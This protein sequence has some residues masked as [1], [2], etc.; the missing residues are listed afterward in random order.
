MDI[1]QGALVLL[2]GCIV[3]F[4]N[5]L[6]AGGSFLTLA[7][8]MAIGLP[9]NIANGTNRVGLLLQNTF[10]SAKFYR[11][12]ILKTKFALIVSLPA[13]LGALSGSYIAVHT[14]N[15]LLKKIIAILMVL[16]S[17]ITVYNPDK[18][19]KAKQYSSKKWL[20]LIIAFFLIGVYGGFIQAGVGFFII[21]ASLWGGFSM[22][23]ANA[24]K[25]FIITLYTLTVLPIFILSHQVNFTIGILLGLGSML[26]ARLAIALSIKKGDRFIRY[27]VLALL[28]VFALKLL[29]IG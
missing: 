2:I 29:I 3:G 10:A 14:P 8:L 26:G 15:S 24:I 17:L 23:E 6:A 20:F 16:I 25:V 4:I 21:A 11:L 12:K 22:V 18:F 28:V 9:P 5:V 19:S 13:V 7:F 1:A 27:A